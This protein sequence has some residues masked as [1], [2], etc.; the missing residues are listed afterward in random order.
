VDP[1][2]AFLHALNAAVLCFDRRYEEALAAANTALAMQPENPIAQ[3]YALIAASNTGR[4]SEAFVALKMILKFFYADPADEEGI[5]QAWA[6]DGLTGATRWAA[7]IMATRNST[8]R[9]LPADTA[10]FLAMAQEWDEAIEW[11]ERAYEIR[12]PNMP[13]ITLPVFDP[14]RSDPRFQDLLRRL[15]LPESRQ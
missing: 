1:V 13:Y 4:H 3:Y 15:N 11:L 7:T 9:S 12:D 5:E 2:N 14:L 6:Q 10:I 8:S